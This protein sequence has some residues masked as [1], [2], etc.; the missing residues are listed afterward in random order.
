MAGPAWSF[1]AIQAFETCPKKLYHSR[2]KKDFPES[3]NAAADYGTQAHKHFENFLSRKIELPMDLM[4]HGK[5]LELLSA[6]NGK[7]LTEQKLAITKDFE[8]TGYFSKDVWGRGAADLLMLG[9]TS[10]LVVDWK[11]GKPKTGF[12]QLNLMCAMVGCYYPQIETYHAAY[13]WAQT[14]E[15]WKITLDKSDLMDVWNDFL[16]RIRKFEQAHKDSEFPAKPS[17]LC[18]K[19]CGVSICAHYQIGS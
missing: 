16:P 5:L 12:D 3:F 19:Y 4:H 17:G 1:S 10:A 8:P 14:K 2:V 13:Y 18:K 11:F 9:E 7:L 15:L 6:F